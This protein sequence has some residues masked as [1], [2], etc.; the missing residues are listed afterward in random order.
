MYNLPGVDDGAGMVIMFRPGEAFVIEGKS[1]D[2]T[3]VL[4]DDVS[5]MVTAGWVD[6][7]DKIP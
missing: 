3:L 1:V 2:F 6:S 4:A 7:I 5:A